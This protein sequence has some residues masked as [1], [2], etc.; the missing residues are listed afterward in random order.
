MRSQLT[1]LLMTQAVADWRDGMQRDVSCDG[2]LDSAAALERGNACLDTIHAT[3]TTTVMNAPFIP[4]W[5]Q[6]SAQPTIVSDRGCRVQGVACY[7][8]YNGG[9]FR[10]LAQ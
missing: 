6:S 3:D 2:K 7:S 9:V 10:C 5:L 8:A 4:A 1:D